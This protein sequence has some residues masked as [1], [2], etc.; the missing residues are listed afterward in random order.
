MTAATHWGAYPSDWDHLDLVCELTEHL[1]PVVSN[2]HAKISPDSKIQG[3]GKTPSRY[4]GRGEMAGF[5][6]WTEY[7]ADTADI[8][9]WSKIPDYGICIQ[10]RKIRAIDVDVD[11]PEEASRIFRAIEKNI[12]GLPLRNRGNSAKFLLAFELEGDFTKRRFKTEHGVIEFLATG[13]QFVSCGCHPSGARYEWPN[14]LPNRFP[15]LTAEQFEA[16]WLELNETFG[17]EDSV[18]S[19]KGIDPTKKRTAA[20]TDDDV[21][22]F[23]EKNWDTYGFDRSGRV[24]IRCPFEDQHTTD[25]GESA[26]SYFPA[27]VGGFMQGHFKCQH[28]HC[29]DREDGDFLQAIGYGIDDFDVIA[30]PKKEIAKKNSALAPADE[31]EYKQRMA[32][33]PSAQL[34]NAHIKDVKGGGRAISANRNSVLAALTSAKYC[35]YQIAFD[36]FKEEFLIAEVT[37]DGDN[38]GFTTFQDDDYAW[39][40]MYL[41]A[42]PIPFEHIP[43]EILRTAVAQVARLNQTDSAQGWLG[44]KK[45]D[46]IPRC[47]RFLIDY[48]GVEDT[49]Y[50][51]AVALYW[52]S[53]QAGRVIKPGI[54]ADMVPIAVGG[55]GAR[56]TSAVA[57]MAPNPSQHLELDFTKKDDDLAR[58]MRGKLVVEIGEMKGANT[59]GI[60]H[61]KAFITRTCEKW[62]P[63]FKEYQT[64]YLRRCM[65]FGTTNDDEPLPDDESGHRRW[66]PFRVPAGFLCDSEGIARDRD[67]LWAE[68]AVLFLENGIMWEAAERLAGDVHIH[69]QK[70]DSWTHILQDWLFGSEMGEAPQ[71]EREGGLRIHDIIAGALNIQPAAINVATERRVGR[72]LKALGLRKT[73]RQNRK[74]WVYDKP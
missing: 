15:K 44:S 29:M 8:T 60:E 32:R 4:N 33:A 31:E 35:G 5:S 3:A 73:V 66:L 47:E 41:E 58:E 62:I 54:K 30:E 74:V 17:V 34:V 43:N 52:W 56:K 64:D 51:R 14:G 24:D 50:H 21:V 28:S 22:R 68:G 37:P 1:L 71:I 59:R 72:C 18:E 10:T 23:L 7:K 12:A 53:A 38:K 9:R 48:F 65:F 6:K 63:K 46:G 2:P 25:S 13:Q 36:K 49:E 16:I 61:V 40:A 55:Q 42:K 57:A 70:E 11:N 27:G 19:R 69:Y 45:W 67:Q 20:D 26:T 39:I